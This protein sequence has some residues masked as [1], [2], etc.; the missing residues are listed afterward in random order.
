MLE[1]IVPDPL[2]TASVSDAALFRT[3]AAAERP[4]VILLDEVDAVFRPKSDRE[5]LRALLN[6]GYRL[7]A[8]VARCEL[9][10]RKVEVRRYSAFGPKVLAG[11]GSLPDT[12]ADRSIPIRLRR[13]ARGEA[14]A[15]FRFR[16]ARAETEDLRDALAAWAAWA[17]EQLVEARPS[18]PPELNDRAAD[19]WEPLLAIADAAGGEWP[20]AARAAA[21]ELHSAEDEGDETFGVQLLADVARVFEATGSDRIST[22]ELVEALKEHGEG[23]WAEWWSRSEDLRGPGHRIA[24]LLRPYGISSKKI[25]AGDRTAQGYEAGQFADAWARYLPVPVFREKGTE[26]RNTAGRRPYSTG[27]GSQP[28]GVEKGL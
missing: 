18:V 21:V 8:D 14:V 20:T 10:G 12:I 5:D 24:R 22:A 9:V 23:P 28:R 6:A 2:R 1:L 3:I 26:H 16:E 13:R 7:G 17:V 19:G 11:I 15:R 27:T 25:R 4:P